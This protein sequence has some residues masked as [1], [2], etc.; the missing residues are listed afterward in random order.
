MPKR[1]KESKQ[2]R[3]A[4]F[5]QMQQYILRQRKCSDGIMIMGKS[6]SINIYLL[7]RSSQSDTQERGPLTVPKFYCMYL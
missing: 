5:V 2:D 6:T 4:H 1:D 7:P 3:E